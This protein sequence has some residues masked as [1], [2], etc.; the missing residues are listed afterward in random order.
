MPREA[1]RS[2][3]APP[4]FPVCPRARRRGSRTDAVMVIRAIDPLKSGAV[5]WFGGRFIGTSNGRTSTSWARSPAL[6]SSVQAK[7]HSSG[8]L[9]GHCPKRHP[10][11]STP[12]GEEERCRVRGSDRAERR[13]RRRLRRRLGLERRAG[14][15]FRPPLNVTDR[16]LASGDPSRQIAVHRD[17]V[18]RLQCGSASSDEGVRLPNSKSQEVTFRR[19]LSHPCG[20]ACGFVQASSATVPVSDRLLRVEFRGK[21]R[22]GPARSPERAGECCADGQNVQQSPFHGTHSTDPPDAGGPNCFRCR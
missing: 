19:R 7:P 1:T 3:G 17:H 14:K 6:D 20:W 9:R 5:Y 10:R 22:D 16:A 13:L 18:A 21:A 4:S 2:A 12:L 8:G 11:E 15:H